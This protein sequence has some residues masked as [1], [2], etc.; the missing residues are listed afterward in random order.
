MARRRR[1]RPLPFSELVQ[2]VPEPSVE[3][4][5]WPQPLREGVWTDADGTVWRLRHNAGLRRIAR[6]VRAADVRV[7][8]VYPPDG[9]SEVPPAQRQALWTAA[10]PHLE[11]RLPTADDRTH[12]AAAEF[13]DEQRREL[14]I[15]ER[16]C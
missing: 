6:L 1:D 7:L 4:E 14:V 8:L 16:S 3:P 2:D 12:Y 11:G 15:V 9:I 5:V 13:R 10:L